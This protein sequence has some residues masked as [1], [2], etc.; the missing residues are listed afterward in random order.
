ML[1]Q[2]SEA[3]AESYTLT[4]LLSKMVEIA[5]ESEVHTAKRLKQK[6]QE[7]YKD[8]IFCCHGNVVCFRNMTKYIINESGTQRGGPI[9]KMKLSI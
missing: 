9:L 6:L 8:F 5:G 3:D 2:W 4:E 1:C 7:H